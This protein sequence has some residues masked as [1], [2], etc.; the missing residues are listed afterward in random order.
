MPDPLCSKYTLLRHLC[1]C[2]IVHYTPTPWDGPFPDTGTYGIVPQIAIGV[3]GIALLLFPEVEPWDTAS[4]FSA[5]TF[6]KSKF[7]LNTLQFSFQAFQPRSQWCNLIMLFIPEHWHYQ[8]PNAYNSSLQNHYYISIWSDSD[9]C[10]EW[11]T[12]LNETYLLWLKVTD[13]CINIVQDFINKWHHLSHLNLNK[14]PAAFLRYL[15][16]GITSHVLDTIV[17]FWIKTR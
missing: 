13:D 9:W 7:Q 3:I 12:T 5:K 16:E 14:M 2:H 1:A 17:G 15:Y 6:Q 4:H 11:T 10:L 8:K